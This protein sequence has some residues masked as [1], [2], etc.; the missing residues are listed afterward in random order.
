M[1]RFMKSVT[2]AVIF[3]I[4]LGK[5]S[6][7][8]ENESKF[9]RKAKENPFVPV[10]KCSFK[11]MNITHHPFPAFLRPFGN[12]LCKLC[13]ILSWN[14]PLMISLHFKTDPPFLGRSWAGIWFLSIF[15]KVCQTVHGKSALCRNGRILSHC[16]LQTDENEKSRRYQDVSS[17]DPHACGCTRLCGWR[18]DCWYVVCSV[19][20]PILFYFESVWN[21]SLT[22]TLLCFF[23]P[24]VL[25]SMYKDYFAKPKEN[26]K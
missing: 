7:I 18:H 3:F 14:W 21:L 20:F 1:V 6:G 17:P 16:W 10:G 19:T 12:L 2:N 8:E 9:L 13:A 11:W 25:F 26:H 23:V 5:M 4:N 22:V 15:K 24:G